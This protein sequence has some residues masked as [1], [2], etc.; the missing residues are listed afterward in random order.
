MYLIFALSLITVLL[1]DEGIIP[2]YSQ[3]EM[4]KPEDQRQPIPNNYCSNVYDLIK[5]IEKK[6]STNIHEFEFFKKYQ[7]IMNYYQEE[8]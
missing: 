2:F 6:G 7:E 5:L 4:T 3:T 1:K 8:I